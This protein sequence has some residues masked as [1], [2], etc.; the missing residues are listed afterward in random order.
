MLR[1][2]LPPARRMKPVSSSAHAVQSGFAPFAPMLFVL[3]WSSGF[4]AAKLGLR[5]IAPFHFLALRFALVL[6]ILLPLAPLFKVR[7][8]RG[9]LLLHAGI[10]GC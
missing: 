3:L 7:W 10:A 4:I 8:P 1:F 5:Y 2:S 6:L 9:R